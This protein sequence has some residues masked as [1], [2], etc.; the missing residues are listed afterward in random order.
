MIESPPRPRWGLSS[1]HVRYAGL[2]LFAVCAI[3]RG[4]YVTWVEFPDRALLEAGLPS[5]DWQ[6]VM[7]WSSHT[8]PETNLLVD[9]GHAWRY[10]TSVRVAA[11]RDVYL[12]EIKDT[13]MAIY[14]HAVAQRVRERIQDLGDFTTLT[15]STA[16]TLARRYDL[17]YLIT[18][19]QVDLPIA[20]RSGPFIVYNLDR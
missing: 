19:H 8:P 3:G 7:D 18:S 10:G 20:H 4:S 15:A 6:R 2:I 5:S 13:G 16:R 14:S 9:P 12:E 11:Q 1:V 17:Q